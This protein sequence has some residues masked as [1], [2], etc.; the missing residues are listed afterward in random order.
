M[1]SINITS[2]VE[3]DAGSL[4]KKLVIPSISVEA[5]PAA[6]PLL[7][8]SPAALR[9]PTRIDTESASSHTRAVESLRRQWKEE[10]ATKRYPFEWAIGL[11]LPFALTLYLLYEQRRMRADVDV[12][13]TARAQELPALQGSAHPASL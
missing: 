11:I 3:D 4:L 12:L 1:A 10:K 13:L 6:H 2:F 5:P 9:P 8:E 7:E